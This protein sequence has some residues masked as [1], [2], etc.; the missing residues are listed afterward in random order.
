MLLFL[1]PFFPKQRQAL[2]SRFSLASPGVREAGSLPFQ[3]VVML[4]NKSS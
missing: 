1:L 4:P 2:Q 3:V